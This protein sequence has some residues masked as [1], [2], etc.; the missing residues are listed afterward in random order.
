MPYSDNMYSSLNENSDG[1]DYTDQLSPSDGQF[2]P[3]SSNETPH[4]PNVL[5]PDPTLQERTE[6]KSRSKA[7]EAD[8]DNLLNPQADPAES[9][10]ESSSQQEQAATATSQLL[11]HHQRNITCSPSSPSRSLRQVLAN[12]LWSSPVYPEAPPAYSP[13]PISP[14]SPTSPGSSPQHD[15]QSN[16]NTFGTSRMMGAP[17][18]ESERLL[19]QQPESMSAPVDGGDESPAWATRARRR[20]PAWL[21]WKYGLLALAILIAAIVFLGGISFASSHP[22]HDNDVSFAFPQRFL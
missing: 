8:E 7:Q 5:I 11:P 19:G 2:P 10:F 16:Y 4:V 17:E 3:T 18:V 1:E 22:S 15:R 6:S 14:F 13:S 20:L 12:R 21:N 9:S